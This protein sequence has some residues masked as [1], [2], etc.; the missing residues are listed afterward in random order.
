MGEIKD[1]YSLLNP[2]EKKETKEY[3]YDPMKVLREREI[4]SDFVYID[5]NGKETIDDKDYNYIEKYIRTNIKE[6]SVLDLGGG[7]THC[8]R[9]LAAIDKITHATSVDI[10][11][12]NNQVT[13]EL[14]EGSKNIGKQQLV[15][16]SDI[17]LLKISASAMAK[18]ESY[19]IKISGTEMMDMLY[20][21]C[22]YKGRPD[23]ITADIIAQAD[24]LG[25]GEMLDNR[26]YDNVMFFFSFFTR[27]REETL[28]LIKNAKQRMNEGGRLI[29]MDVWEFEGVRDAE[30]EEDVVRSE[31]KI[32]AE[33]YPNPWIWS[34][35]E[36]I[37]MLKEAGFSQ[38]RTEEK[39]VEE[40]EAE[41]NE[42]G[43]Y[44]GFVAE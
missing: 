10:S 30:S 25:S 33:K 19:D 15:K 35:E 5:E 23:I 39:K 2:K 18:D 28:N 22:Q 27:N 20:E 37:E 34:T 31:D 4:N 42:L 29:I 6:G 44:T 17:N 8:H 40:S 38:V 32:V 11:E 36:M 26:K 1:P 14:L 3:K 24:G 12:A 7:F 16:K 41:K 9:I 43:G 13:K 21:K